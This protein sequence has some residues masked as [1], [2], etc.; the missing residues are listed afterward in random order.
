MFFYFLITPIFAV[1]CQ[2]YAPIELNYFPVVGMC[3]IKRLV[4]TYFD[5]LCVYST[6]RANMM[7]IA[8]SDRG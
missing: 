4:G 3:F 8:L 1:M 7:R 5:P 2:L 6:S